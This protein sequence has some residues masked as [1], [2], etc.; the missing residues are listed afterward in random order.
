VHRQAVPD[1]DLAE[2]ATNHTTRITSGGPARD[3]DDEP[4]E[5]ARKL[6]GAQRRKQ[7]KEEKK[8]R[9]GA[10]KGRRWS[11][12]HDELNL[13][14]RLASGQLCEFGEAYVPVN[15]SAA[16]LPVIHVDA[17]IRTTFGDIFPRSQEI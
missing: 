7:A 4:P 8:K 16:S 14:W 11:K 2:G 17:D 1:D 12:V 13:C 15:C 9:Q 3:N 10:N 6:T 5:G